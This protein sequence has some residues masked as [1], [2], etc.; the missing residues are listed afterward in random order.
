MQKA[1]DNWCV[2]QSSTGNISGKLT[3]GIFP[4]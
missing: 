2:I 3:Y 1:G 4:Q